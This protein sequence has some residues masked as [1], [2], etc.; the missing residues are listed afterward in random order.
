MKKCPFKQISFH[1]V[2]ECGEDC[3]LYIDGKCAFVVMAEDHPAQSLPET[4]SDKDS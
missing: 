4:I 3:A 1:T 2:I